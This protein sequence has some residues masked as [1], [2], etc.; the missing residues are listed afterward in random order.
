M[1][2]V[3]TLNQVQLNNA[4]SL[5]TIVNPAGAAYTL[6][7]PPTAGTSGQ[8][9]GNNG[10]GLTAWVTAL[11]SSTAFINGGNSFGA[12]SSLG[13][14][15]AFDLNLKTSNISRVTVAAAS[16]NVGI[17]TT[18]PAYSL[19]VIGI[20]KAE[21]FLPNT[22]GTVGA[23]CS[24]VGA[25]VKD[26]A[27]TPVYCSPAPSYWTYLYNNQPASTTSGATI[28]FLTNPVQ[29]TL[30]GCGTFALNN[31]KS[32]QTYRFLIKGGNSLNCAFTAFSD[33]GL[34][35]L[36]LKSNT[37]NLYATSTRWAQA[38][39]TSFGT[40]AIVTWDNGIYP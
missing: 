6:T 38:T 16:G 3:A 5:V 37:N 31:I 12:A 15:D 20:V 22:A 17:G 7:L 1:A 27:G 25:I 14:N 4:G 8:V 34:T 36:P 28:D 11:T 40:E 10:A 35:A 9:L 30:A 2:N 29:S 13:N 39:I 32:G 18:T 24:P 26:N 23:S 33:T 21:R 19:D